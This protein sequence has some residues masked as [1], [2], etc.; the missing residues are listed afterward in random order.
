[1]M[2]IR[3]SIAD[4]SDSRA[5]YMSQELRTRQDSK[6]GL[7]TEVLRS[8]GEISLKVTGTSM[9]PTVWPGDVLKIQFTEFEQVL[10]GDIVLYTRQNRF[11]IH[12]VTGKFNAP[13]ERHL[14]MRGDAM[15]A[16]DPPVSEEE[17]LGRVVGIQRFG[18]VIEP[19]RQLTA[20]CRM[21]A[22]LLCRCDVLR[23]LVLR[24]R[25]RGRSDCAR[26]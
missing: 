14:S 13:G 19:S 7:A 23:G 16:A 8:F 21:I 26:M 10:L 11:F 5:K 25:A 6:C 9:L 3:Q 17:L 2:R 12:R 22:T 1:M 18:N 20:G 4:L 15:A 24:L